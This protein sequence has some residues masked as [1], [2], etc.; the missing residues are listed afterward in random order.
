[1]TYMTYMWCN[2]KNK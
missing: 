1:M 2:K